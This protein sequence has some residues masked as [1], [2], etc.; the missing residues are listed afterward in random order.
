MTAQDFVGPLKPVLIGKDIID[1]VQSS[2]CLGVT[3]DNHLHWNLHISGVSKSFKA[4]VVSY[5][6][7][8]TYL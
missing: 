1:Y 4:K 6:G 3:I 8:L 5:E 2:K 7:C